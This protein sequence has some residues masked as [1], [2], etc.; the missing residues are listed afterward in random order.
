MAADQPTPRVNVKSI[1]LE[2]SELAPIEAPVTVRMEYEIDAALASAR[3]QLRYVADHAHKRHVVEIADTESAPLVAGAH[4]FEYTI[5]DIGVANLSRAVV[6]NV[7]LL[8]LTLLD[9]D[10]EILQ[11][12]MVTQVL[13]RDGQLVRLV[14]NPLE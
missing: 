12:S 2:P 4:Q 3:W 14:L 11:V 8:L 13:E 1:A 6:L 5:D 7:G 9:G 10:A